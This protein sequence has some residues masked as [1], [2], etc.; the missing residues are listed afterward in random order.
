MSRIDVLADRAQQLRAA[1]HADPPLVLPNAWDASSARAVVEAGFP[2][3]ATT[4]GGVAASLG[5]ADHEQA[6]PEEMFVAIARVATAVDVP[7][8]ADIE[9]GYGLSPDELVGRLLDMGV[10]GCNLEDTDH[11]QERTLVPTEAQAERLA[12]VRAAAQQ[13]GV[14]I[15]VNARVDVFIQRLD[16]PE[17]LVAAALERAR[18]YAAAGADCVYP[19]IAD[20]AQLAEFCAAHQGPVNAMVMP[21]RARLSALLGLGVARISFGSGL[22]RA[23]VSDLQRRLSAIAAASDDWPTQPS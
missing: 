19:I 2:V 22:H 1:H 15:V 11:H 9:A 10:V 17:R 8:T 21:G 7:V 20:E 3:V 5:Y 12:A 6:P 23:A 18:A 14:D 16:P 4:S 13:R